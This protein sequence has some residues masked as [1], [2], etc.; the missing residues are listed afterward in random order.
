MYNV[1][2]IILAW[3]PPKA[4]LETTRRFRW[5]TEVTSGWGE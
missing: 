5:Y 3:V 1:Y 2:D 4:E